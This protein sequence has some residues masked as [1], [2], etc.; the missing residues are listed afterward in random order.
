M[1]KYNYLDPILED[2][3]NNALKVLKSGGII[4]YPTDT[5]WGLGCDP[6]NSEAIKRIFKIKK[7]ND[8]KGLIILVDTIDRVSNYIYK[9]P[10][11]AS[12]IIS[13]SN[14]PITI[15]YEDAVNLA[16]E[17]ISPDG[18]I[19]IRVSKEP[20]SNNLI[21]RYNKAIVSTSANISGEKTA[22]NYSEIE[23]VI[24]DSVDYV[25]KWNQKNKKGSSASGII[26]LGKNNEVK[27]IRK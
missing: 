19:G 24:I 2:E 18:S 10:D 15:V 23:Q 1:K 12:E 4:L 27:I 9:I 14:K 8:V 22:G 25:V 26:K 6:D 7:R 11:M 20:F 21:R 5:I 16:P 17:L 3:I 13:L